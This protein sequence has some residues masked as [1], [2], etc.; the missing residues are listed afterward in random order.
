MKSAFDARKKMAQEGI[1]MPQIVLIEAGKIPRD[2]SAQ[3]E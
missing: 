2:A 3:E 1:L